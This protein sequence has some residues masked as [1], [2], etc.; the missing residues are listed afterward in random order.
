L[1]LT[2]SLTLGVTISASDRTRGATRSASEGFASLGRSVLSATIIASQFNAI[3]RATIRVGQGLI[4]FV[5]GAVQENV[6]FE[7]QLLEV[8]KTADLT[9]EQMIRLRQNTLELTKVLPLNAKQLTNIAAIG[10][11]LGIKTLPE[12]AAL[13]ETVAKTVLGTNLSAEEAASA[14]GK[15]NAVFK[16]GIKSSEN[17]A[18]ALLAVADNAATTESEIVNVTLRAGPVAKLL[19]L[20]AESTFA[21]AAAMKDA[22][23]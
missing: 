18:S 7:E 16:F 17:V 23:D 10:G 4:G 5:T 15:L 22:G 9:N 12:L 11:R 2:D 14:F 19:G 6:G 13:Q 21:F 8:V 1:A 20:T 3:A